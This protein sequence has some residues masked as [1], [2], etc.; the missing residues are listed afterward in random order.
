MILFNALL[1]FVNECLRIC[2]AS[3]ALMSVHRMF[4]PVFQVLCNTN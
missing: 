3:K 4:I 2:G 1:N